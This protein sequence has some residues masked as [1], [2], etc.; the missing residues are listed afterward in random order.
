[1][2]QSHHGVIL[3][4]GLRFQGV[5]RVPFVWQDPEG[6]KGEVRQDLGGT[7]D[8]GATILARAGLQTYFGNQ[9]HDLFDADA[10][11]REGILIA[12]HGMAVFKDPE[13]KA[14]LMSYITDEWRLSV[15]ECKCWIKIPQKC[16]CKF[17]H[18][19][20]SGISRAGDWRLRSW[21]AGRAV[22]GAV[23]G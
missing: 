12:D 5:V 20:G 2:Q 13:A 15:W 16:W 1:M 23:A 14:G 3:K 17:P 22:S 7:I 4:L 11:P 21:A 6:A 19:T 8:I 9:G 10:A 18:L